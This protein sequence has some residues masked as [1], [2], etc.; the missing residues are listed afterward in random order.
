MHDGWH[1]HLHPRRG[2]LIRTVRS[3]N[4]A[5]V[6]LAAALSLTAGACSGDEG[7]DSKDT[8]QLIADLR[9]DGMN[10]KAA[11]CVARAFA[12][13]GLSNDEAKAVGEGDVGDIDAD[14]LAVYSQSASACLGFTVEI[15]TG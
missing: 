11:E 12:E 2:Q 1:R 14:A 9:A 15:P 8:T 4:L 13:A 7:G 6:V 5:V 3:R 10:K